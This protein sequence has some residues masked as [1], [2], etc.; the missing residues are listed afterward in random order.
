MTHF[1]HFTRLVCA[2]AA[3]AGLAMS[4]QAFDGIQTFTSGAPFFKRVITNTNISLSSNTTF[5]NVPGTLTSVF[6]PGGTTVLVSVAYSAESAC[7]GGGVGNPNWCELQ[8]LIGGV[9]GSPQASTFG[10]DTYAF[11]TT[12]RGAASPDSWRGH[13]LSR[14]R[15]ITNTGN[16]PLAVPIAVQSKIVQFGTEPSTLWLDDSAMVIEM[17]RGCTV[18]NT[19]NGASRSVGDLPR[20]GQR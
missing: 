5:A 7:Y 16:A 13:A 19:P 14:H 3:L 20:A 18:T 15:C 4:A 11:T 1:K 10:G 8:V 17:T 12:D 9:E 2:S 6:V